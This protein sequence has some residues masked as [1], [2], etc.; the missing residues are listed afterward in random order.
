MRKRNVFFQFLLQSWHG[1][2]FFAKAMFS[3]KNKNDM[4]DGKKNDTDIA[5][6][7]PPAMRFWEE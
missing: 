1:F 2:V 7:K 6:Q 5:D 3:S 4:E